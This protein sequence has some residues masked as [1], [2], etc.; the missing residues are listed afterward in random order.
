MKQNQNKNKKYVDN[1]T[2]S[3]RVPIMDYSLGEIAVK[4]ALITSLSGSLAM[5]FMNITHR[6]DNVVGYYINGY[7][8]NDVTKAEYGYTVEYKDGQVITYTMEELKEIV[9][10]KYI[11][12][13]DYAVPDGHHMIIGT[14]SDDDKSNLALGAELLVATGS[15]I[16]LA[17]TRDM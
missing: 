10:P 11:G 16:A 12:A 17:K 14:K 2:V 15:G 13:K 5:A 3:S 7:D 1:M 8:V 6:D 4:L 9:D